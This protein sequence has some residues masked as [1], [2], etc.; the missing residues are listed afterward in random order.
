M[1]NPEEFTDEELARAEAALKARTEP[2]AQE[3]QRAHER[4]GFRFSG[5]DMYY[6]YGASPDFSSAS[7]PIKVDGEEPSHVYRVEGAEG[8]KRMRETGELAS[9]FGGD[10]SYTHVSKLPETHY[11][12]RGSHLLRIANAPGRFRTKMTLTRSYG[13]ADEPIPAQD[14]EDLGPVTADTPSASGGPAE[15]KV[16]QEDYYPFNEDNKALGDIY[17]EQMNRKF[18][19]G[20]TLADILSPELF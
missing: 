15:S 5:G 12:S 13:V 3:W 14:V 10:S 16:G 2:R 1:L 18:R 17:M 20:A 7:G 9:T 19:S 4:V 8:V 11:A 6:Q